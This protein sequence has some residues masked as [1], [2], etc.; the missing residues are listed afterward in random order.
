MQVRMSIRDA[1][2]QREDKLHKATLFHGSSML[3]GVNCLEPGQV[4]K[5]HSHAGQEK[6]QLVHEGRSQ[7]VNVRTERGL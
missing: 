1:I 3:L 4:S 7:G 6:F 5:L 2:G